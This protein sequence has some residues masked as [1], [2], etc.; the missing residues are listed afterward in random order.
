MST[1][2][3]YSHIVNISFNVV[4]MSHSTTYTVQK[5]LPCPC[6]LATTTHTDGTLL[7]SDQSSDCG[8][9][10]YQWRFWSDAERVRKCRERPARVGQGH[11]R[12]DVWGHHQPSRG[13]NN[14]LLFKT[15]LKTIRDEITPTFSAGLDLTF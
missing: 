5:Q 13:F 10:H 11:H 3:N 7:V 1:A 8:C 15:R 2:G 4:I 12:L 14:Q 9:R 6:G